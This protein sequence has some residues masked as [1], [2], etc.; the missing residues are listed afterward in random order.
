MGCKA[1]TRWMLAPSCT[2]ETEREVR[3]RLTKPKG[4]APPASP[5]RVQSRATARAL[6][7]WPRD[8]LLPLQPAHRSQDRAR[9]GL[10][11]SEQSTA[12]PWRSSRS[13]GR[14]SASSC[15][16]NS[17][18]WVCAEREREQM[19]SLWFCLSSQSLLFSFSITLLSLA[20]SFRSR[21]FCALLGH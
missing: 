13:Q 11:D 3:K 6:L 17:E 5:P 2:P 19:T 20:C 12:L 10:G 8:H 18:D 15:L 1:L 7:Q 4:P 16:H 14:P 9:E 21:A